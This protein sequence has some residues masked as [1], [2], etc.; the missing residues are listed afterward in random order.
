MRLYQ[1]NEQKIDFNLDY[2]NKIGISSV[3]IIIGDE[4]IAD[5]SLLEQTYWV[6]ENAKNCFITI[7]AK[8]N[9]TYF[10]Y[11]KEWISNSYEAKV[12]NQKEIS[13][14][15]INET[16]P[17]VPQSEENK[18]IPHNS[19]IIFDVKQKLITIQNI[20]KGKLENVLR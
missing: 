1:L 10:F 17:I 8:I 13:D 18:A 7:K 14:K 2:A 19:P 3:Q 11:G 9:D 15:N 20:M 4:I 6:L 12:D 5:F 16:V